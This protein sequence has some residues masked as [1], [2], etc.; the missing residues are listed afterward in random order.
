MLLFWLGLCF[1]VGDVVLGFRSGGCGFNAFRLES[2][3]CFLVYGDLSFATMA[4]LSFLHS[5]SLLA[6]VEGTADSSMPFPSGSDLSGIGS[7][8]LMKDDRPEIAFDGER[9]F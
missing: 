9:P 2:T 7:V 6:L 4:L 8:L 3:L 1:Q 5:T